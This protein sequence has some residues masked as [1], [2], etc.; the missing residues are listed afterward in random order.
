MIAL[1]PNYTRPKVRPTSATRGGRKSIAP[2]GRGCFKTDTNCRLSCTLKAINEGKGR[3]PPQSSAEGKG[4]LRGK[5]GKGRKVG[6]R[7]M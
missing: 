2:S 5:G 1:N 3:H 4:A 7:N 6:E